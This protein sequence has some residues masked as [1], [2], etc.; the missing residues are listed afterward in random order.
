[1]GTT[2]PGRDDVYTLEKRRRPDM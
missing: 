1:M 2:T